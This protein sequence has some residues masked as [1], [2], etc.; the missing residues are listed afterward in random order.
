MWLPH[1]PTYFSTWYCNV[2]NGIFLGNDNAQ[3]QQRP[4]RRFRTWDSTFKI[5]ATRQIMWESVSRSWFIQCALIDTI[6]ND[7]GINDSRTKPIPAKV[8]LRL[9]AFKDEPALFDLNFNYRSV[10]S[11]LN[12][13]AQ[14]TCPDIMYAV[15]QIPKKYSSDPCQSHGE[16]IL[17]LICY[18]KK[19]RE[20]GTCFKPDPK[21]G[22]ECYCNADFSGL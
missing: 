5:K 14:T 13:L 6:I 11:K 9:H 10:V 16:A 18:L 17:Y 15:H 12:Y 1:T 20:L 22:F 21:K 8:S 3:L 19:T 4:S 7:V 2:D